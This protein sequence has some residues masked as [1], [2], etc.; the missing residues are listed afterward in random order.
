QAEQREFRAELHLSQADARQRESVDL[1]ACPP[2]LVCKNCGQHYL[3][4]YYRNFEFIDGKLSGGDL[5]GDNIVWEVVDETTGVRILFTN[6][7]ISEIEADDDL[8][9]QRLNKKRRQIYFC[10]HCGTLHAHQGQCQQALCKRQ[11]PLVPI[12]VIQLNE[13]NKLM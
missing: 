13:Q 7:F 2:L 1:A 11:G 6:R 10:H 3:E 5:E 8:A 9:T 12:W 4:G